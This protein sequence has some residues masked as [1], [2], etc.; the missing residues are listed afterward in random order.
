M[1]L[2]HLNHFMPGS[3]KEVVKHQY[4]PIFPLVYDGAFGP[5]RLSRVC[6]HKDLAPVSAEPATD[7]APGMAG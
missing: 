5:P 6:G 3:T 2:N 1:S 7:E 4:Q